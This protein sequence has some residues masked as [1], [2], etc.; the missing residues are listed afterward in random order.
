MVSGRAEPEEKGDFVNKHR[1]SECEM[2]TLFNLR[3]ISVFE[4]KRMDLPCFS[5]PRFIGSCCVS[6]YL[7]LG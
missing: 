4:Y 5:F 3:V 7:I 6:S 1:A 2:K